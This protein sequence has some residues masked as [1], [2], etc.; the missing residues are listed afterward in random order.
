ML[1]FE[2]SMK[3]RGAACK[4]R[5]GSPLW[6]I[7]PI[8]RNASGE[9]GTGIHRLPR[10]SC[11]SL[12]WPVQVSHGLF[13]LKD[14]QLGTSIRWRV[15]PNSEERTRLRSSMSGALSGNRTPS[16]H[17]VSRHYQDA[18]STLIIMFGSTAILP[19][20]TKRWAEA[21]VLADCINV[22]VR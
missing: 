2:H 6:N 14:G 7:T 11:L 3:H 17:L 16:E 9:N 18:Y 12:Q 13:V 22:K 8:T 1:T 4:T 10:T 15:S 20:R 5:C 21:K 19:P